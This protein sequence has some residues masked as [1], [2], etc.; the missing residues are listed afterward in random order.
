MRQLNPALRMEVSPKSV[1]RK[2]RKK[3]VPV[4]KDPVHEVP[5]VDV[6]QDQPRDEVGDDPSA[7]DERSDRGNAGSC[8]EANYYRV[9]AAALVDEEHEGTYDVI[10]APLETDQHI[11]DP[12]QVVEEGS[13]PRNL[14]SLTRSIAWRFMTFLLLGRGQ[15]P[16]GPSGE[17]DPL[18]EAEQVHPGGGGGI[19]KHNAALCLLLGSS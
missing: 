10:E 12:V 1:T 16:D 17:L 14:P 8:P 4:Q 19:A 6:H 3:Q 2:E 9:P 15:G 13:R 5:S 11:P 7:D 18:Q